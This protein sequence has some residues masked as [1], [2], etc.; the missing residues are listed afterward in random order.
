MGKLT[1]SARL[2][3]GFGLVLVMM[4]C[5]ILIAL[6]RFALISEINNKIIEKDWV[7]AEAASTINTLTRANA[8]NTMELLIAKDKAQED[9]IIERIGVT[10]KK[11]SE[12][13]EILNKLIY[14]K[15][16][17]DLLAKIVAARTNYVASWKI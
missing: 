14:L 10:K 17:K 1:V 3:I 8:R 15:E 9:K 13:F 16:G 4:T 7:K 2:G 12:S 5:I 6:S 11:I